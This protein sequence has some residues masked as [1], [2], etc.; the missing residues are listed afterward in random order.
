MKK[1]VFVTIVITILIL[2]GILTSQF[3][4]SDIDEMP[5]PSFIEAV[6]YNEVY[7]VTLNGDASHFKTSLHS[8]K[9]EE[10]KVLN[11]K[12]DNFIEYLLINGVAVEYEEEG[13]PRFLQIPLAL[14][15][16]SA[17]IWII[18]K[19]SNQS[20]Q[21]LDSNKDSESKSDI[22]FDDIAGNSEAKLMVEDII[23]FLEEPD[24]YSAVAHEC[25]RD[26]YFM[27]LLELVKL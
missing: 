1:S 15:I 18:K 6:N 3:I 11:P 16:I 14:I 8:N 12:T 25:Q 22:I 7:S 5:Y 17:I 13:L 23:H 4:Y 10:Y 2:V 20:F 24:K 26:Y 21:L 9:D 19:N 27:D